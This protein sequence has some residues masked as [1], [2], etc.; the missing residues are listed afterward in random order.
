MGALGSGKPF[1][2]D[3]KLEA[4]IMLNFLMGGGDNGL[5]KM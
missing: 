2:Q 1:A 5:G 3:S 4:S